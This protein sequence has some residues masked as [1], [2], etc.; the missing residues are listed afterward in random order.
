[1]LILK[2]SHR[3]VPPLIT[4]FS[5]K[6]IIARYY[7]IIIIIKKLL[8]KRTFKNTSKNSQVSYVIKI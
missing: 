3:T 7:F 8:Y 4:N 6:K 2:P 5:K 1:M